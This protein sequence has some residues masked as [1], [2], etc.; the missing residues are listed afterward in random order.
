MVKYKKK[1]MDARVKIGILA[2][3]TLFFS[4]IFSFG[5]IDTFDYYKINPVYLVIIGGIG[6][7]ILLLAGGIYTLTAISKKK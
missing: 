1:S 6:L 4:T 7:L 5:M 2:I 3:L